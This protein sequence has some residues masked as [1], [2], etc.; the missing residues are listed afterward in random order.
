MLTRSRCPTRRLEGRLDNVFRARASCINNRLDLDVQFQPAPN[1]NRPLCKNRAENP[2]H[3]QRTS[4]PVI[5]QP[6]AKFVRGVVD[7]EGP[8][9]ACF[10]TGISTPPNHQVH[11]ISRRLY[12]GWLR[13]GSASAHICSGLLTHLARYRQLL[14]R[15]PKKPPFPARDPK[16]VPTTLSQPVPA[17]THSQTVIPVCPSLYKMP[18]FRAFNVTLCSLPGASYSINSYLPLC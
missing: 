9:L 8:R 1:A 4:T 10:L 11:V 18:Y 7:H 15:G 6:V 3:R 16:S 13:P 12:S 17:R 2:R 5:K 14:M